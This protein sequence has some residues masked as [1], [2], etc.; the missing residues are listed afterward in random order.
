MQFKPGDH[1]VYPAYGAGTIL[2]TEDRAF[3]REV[4]TYYILKMVADEGEF[5]VPVDA[6][7]S[8]GFR[9]IIP[10]K[11]I[12]K[13]LKGKPELLPDDYKIRQSQISE[14]LATSDAINLAQAARNTAWFAGH[15][16][17]TGRD[18]QLYEDLQTQLASELSLSLVIPLNDAVEQLLETLEQI[19]IKGQEDQLALEEAAAAAAAAEEEAAL[20]D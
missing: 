7:E 17:L 12:F 15:R 5:M 1:V 13:E 19:T 2:A 4:T 18:V 9:S 14:L 20:Q 6:A 11:S 3:S 16:S 10:H 8:L